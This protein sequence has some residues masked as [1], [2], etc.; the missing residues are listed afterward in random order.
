MIKLTHKPTGK[1]E[2]FKASDLAVKLMAIPKEQ[3]NE[4]T[5]EVV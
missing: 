5:Y 1:T 3:I 4:Y 2:T